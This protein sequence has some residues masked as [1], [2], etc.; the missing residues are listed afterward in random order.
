MPRFKYRTREKIGQ[1]AGDK[2]IVEFFVDYLI[3]SQ[4]DL[5]A[6]RHWTAVGTAKYWFAVYVIEDIFAAT[7]VG[8]RRSII[9]AE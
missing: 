8:W 4:F 6:R 2:V 7:A 9:R 1:F 3:Q 5:I